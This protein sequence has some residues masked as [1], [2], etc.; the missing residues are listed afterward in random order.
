MTGFLYTLSARYLVRGRG[1]GRVRLSARYLVRGRGR[2]RVR[3]SARYL[4]KEG[5]GL[6]AR[7]GATS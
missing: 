6:K 4:Q 2:G 5:E 1:R 7:V 3:L